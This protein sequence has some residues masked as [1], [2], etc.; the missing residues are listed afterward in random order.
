MNENQ[1]S[2][3]IHTWLKHRGA[4]LV[5]AEIMIPMSIG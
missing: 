3:Y 1:K 5:K 4:R 2:A